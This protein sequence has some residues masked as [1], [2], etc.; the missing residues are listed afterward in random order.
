MKLRKWEE[1]EE[2]EE[3]DEEEEDD[4]AIIIIIIVIIITIENGY[5]TTYLQQWQFPLHKYV[6]K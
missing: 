5:S 1:E 4:D 2:E 3:E 6:N